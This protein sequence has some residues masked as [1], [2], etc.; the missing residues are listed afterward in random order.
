MMSASESNRSSVV[1]GTIVGA[2]VGAVV[3][4]LL[5]PKSGREL[6]EDIKGTVQTLQSKSQ[7]LFE[8]AKTT[9]SDTIQ[10][11]KENG[12]DLLDK[13]YRVADSA[14]QSAR[15]ATDSIAQAVHKT[16][17]QAADAAHRMTDQAADTAH[18]AADS[19]AN[20]A[21]KAT[22]GAANVSHDAANDMKH[23]NPADGRFPRLRARGEESPNSAEQC[24]G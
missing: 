7:E 10:Y 13:A 2:S 4:L 18:K 5:A 16:T 12:A 19:A 3:A 20:T 15:T 6:R 14:A 1:V 11:V 9:T 8:Q 22:D 21:H 23:L 24:A 17:D